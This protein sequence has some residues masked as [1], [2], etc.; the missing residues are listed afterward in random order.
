VVHAPLHNLPR[1][2]S[3]TS[4]AMTC[5]VTVGM[6]LAEAEALLEGDPLIAPL[7]AATD[8]TELR[9]LAV[10]CGRFGPVIGVEEGEQPESLL[11]DVTGCAPFFGSEHELVRQAIALLAEQRYAA[12]AGIADTVGAAWAAS[13]VAGERIV[14]VPT[15][16]GDAWL[17]RRPVSALRLD[18]KTLALLDGLGLR[19]IGDVLALPQSELPS[20]FGPLLSRRIG[21]V[22]GTIPEPIEPVRP[23]VPLVVRWSAETPL[24]DRSGIVAVL[25]WLVGR[26]VARL[27]VWDGITALCCRFDGRPLV[28]RSASPARSADR[29]MSLVIL[30]LDREPPPR[31][32]SRIT[33]T[34]ETLRLPPPDRA[35]LF[36]G[37]TTAGQERQFRRLVER[38]AG[39][40]GEHAV[41]RPT[42]V[43]DHLPEQSVKVLPMA[44]AASPSPPMTNVSTVATRPIILLPTPEPVDVVA[45]YPDGPPHRL[46]R[47]HRSNAL[48]LAI[49]PE[50]FET[51][52]VDGPEA[53]RDYWRIE[54]DE[55]ERLWLFRCRRSGHWFLHGLFG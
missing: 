4:A 1:V 46:T 22:L 34:A 28:V 37:R 6:P 9:R 45:V 51:G 35:D 12:H 38:I 36:G 10:L 43:G 55:A 23:A 40:L 50:R 20:R 31:E 32:V 49:G 21:Q 47:G 52:W 13:H 15:G 53:R 7:D 44:A 8:L 48:V 18:M 41:T 54:T 5:G 33:V 24:T 17:S 42:P 3:L 39:R 29:L 14:I 27:P 25:T 30:A 2:F 11:I 19:T 16:N 26:L